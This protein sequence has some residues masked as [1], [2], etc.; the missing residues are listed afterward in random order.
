[1]SAREALVWDI[2]DGMSVADAARLHGVDRSCANKWWRRFRDEG[3]AGLEERSRRPE[4]SPNQ[5]PQDLVDEL[6]ALKRK[7]PLLGPEKL[8]D[9]M[10]ELHGKHV[11]ATS[12]AG[13][14]LDRHGLV[15]KRRKRYA[16]PG[17]IEHAPFEVAG[18]GDSMTADFK[19]QI[20]M[21]NGA[22][23]YPLTLVDPFSRCVLDIVALPSTH[24]Q[25]V[26]A[27]F[28][29]VF[30]EHG[31]PRQIITDNGTPFCSSQSLGGLTQLS[32]RW[33]ELGS[34]PVR[35]QPGRPGQNG[36]HERMHRTLAD[37]IELHPRKDLRGHQR[38]FDTFVHEFNTIRSHKGLG[39]RKPASVYRPYRPYPKSTCI[40]Y[41][42]TMETRLVNANGE[43][44]LK[45]KAV[46]LSDVLIGAHVGL[47]QTGEDCLAVYFG[48]LK[49]GYLD[50]ARM[51]AVNRKPQPSSIASATR[52]GSKG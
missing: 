32:R 40:E 43:I 41:D 50:L 14:I 34:R 16:S 24:M 36:S 51:R 37:W 45:G 1:M 48:P 44:K 38:S 52:G 31:V 8:V 29:R 19:G 2:S 46:F 49:L 35:I 28:E 11:M 7:H 4:S 17:R 22:L 13:T 3:P 18:A 25:P 12:T 26:I 42:S 30:R 10:N 21:G 47:I 9:H 6:L 5:T 27:A 23:C 33:I 39:R 20:R 15:K